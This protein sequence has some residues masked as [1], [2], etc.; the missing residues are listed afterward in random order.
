MLNILSLFGL[1][2]FMLGFLSLSKVEP[3]SLHSL[4]LN[5][6][7]EHNSTYDNVYI[8]YIIISC[9]TDAVNPWTCVYFLKTWNYATSSSEAKRH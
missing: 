4:V 8:L 5:E 2:V 7:G 3:T 6:G 1:C 9:L